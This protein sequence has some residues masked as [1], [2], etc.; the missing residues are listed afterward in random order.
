MLEFEHIFIAIGLLKPLFIILSTTNAWPTGCFS[1]LSL[2]E[3]NMMAKLRTHLSKRVFIFY[4]TYS[5]QDK[6]IGEQYS[7]ESVILRVVDRNEK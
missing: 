7:N 6:S 5:L 1:Y 3:L 4:E 2:E